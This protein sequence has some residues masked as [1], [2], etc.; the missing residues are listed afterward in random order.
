MEIKK[1]K[2]ADLER[3]RATR[4]L[5][6]LIIG[7]TLF[8]A[9]I[10]IP[11]GSSSSPDD[12][13]LL[14][15]LFH[16]D[17]LIPL[18]TSTRR[19]PSEPLPKAHKTPETIVV[20][21]DLAS[22]AIPE[23]QPSATDGDDENLPEVVEERPD[24]TT[25]HEE[26]AVANATNDP[27]K[28]RVVEGLPEFPGGAS[29]LMKWLTENLKYPKTAQRKRVQGKVVVSFIVN[30]DG[31]LSDMKIVT[32]LD[33]DCDREAMRVMAMM[34]A[35]KAGTQNDRPC[36]TMVAIPIVFKL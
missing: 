23:T 25:A 21:D 20:T 32:S 14:D 15:E 11:V 36:R 34:P 13:E 31:S 7:L 30:T 35:W 22:E 26:P 24:P 8:F 27:G 17:N 9:A 28:L 3:G 5:L 12:T 16:E 6:G 18:T 19:E 10:E 33:P 29:E 2:R 1:S 4:F